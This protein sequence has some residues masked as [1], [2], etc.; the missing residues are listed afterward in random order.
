MANPHIENLGLKLGRKTQGED[1]D[2]VPRSLGRSQL[3]DPPEFFGHDLWN[4]YEVS[5]LQPNGKPVVHHMQLRYD[6]HSP[7]IV[8][9]KSLKL[10][11][12][13]FNNQH[14]E[15]LQQFSTRISHAL[16]LC[17]GARVELSFFQ[18][19]QSPAPKSLDGL[20]I[21]ELQPSTLSANYDPIL[22]QD[23]HR[24][25]PHRYVSHLLRTNCPVT[26]QPDWGAV[27]IKFD[28]DLDLVPESLLAY[29]IS[30]RNHQD[31]HESC[32]ETIYTDLYHLLKPRWLEVA[33]YYT[34][35]GGLDINPHRSS[36]M[37]YHT[38]TEPVWR[39]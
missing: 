11:L 15:D 2:P 9:S 26:N 6:A 23:I 29:L 36:R 16:T 35:R 12:N 3:K 18:T 4:A 38:R 19:D 32:C 20:C 31:F 1:L 30:F 8:E 34:R 7:A 37:S 17:V 39:Q 5:Y 25:G 10:F 24:Q 28:G 22:L 13:S 33:C 14:F 21:D 27:R